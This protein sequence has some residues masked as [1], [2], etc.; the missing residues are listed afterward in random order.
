MRNIFPQHKNKAAAMLAG[1]TSPPGGDRDKERERK[2]ERQTRRKRKKNR[3]RG[4]TKS[5]RDNIE[6]SPQFRTML[7]G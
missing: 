4:M 7:H 2:R 5:Q 6:I 3:E 1:N